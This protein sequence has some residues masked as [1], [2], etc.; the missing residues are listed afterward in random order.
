MNCGKLISSSAVFNVSHPFPLRKFHFSSLKDFKIFKDAAVWVTFDVL[1]NCTWITMKSFG[2]C[3][4][5][6]R[7][8]RKNDQAFL[9]KHF[10]HFS[11]PP[12]GSIQ[13]PASQEKCIF[14]YKLVKHKSK[15]KKI[16]VGGNDKLQEKKAFFSSWTGNA[17]QTGF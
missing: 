13:M 4:L 5:H 12:K 9:E 6:L 16:R 2:V 7:T 14:L 3:C 11:T 8:I 10:F 15:R 17:L 1:I